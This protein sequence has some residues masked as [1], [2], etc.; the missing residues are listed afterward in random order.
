MR[1][2]VVFTLVTA[3]APNPWHTR[4]ATSVASESES[5]HPAEAMVKSSSPPMYIF[6]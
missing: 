6:R 4:A 5:A 3:A 1:M 2:S